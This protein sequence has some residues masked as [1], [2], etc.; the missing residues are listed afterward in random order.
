VIYNYIIS[1]FNSCCVRFSN[2]TER[3]N[4]EIGKELT[5]RVNKCFKFNSFT[6]WLR[7]LGSTFSTFTFAEIDTINYTATFYKIKILFMH[8]GEKK[9]KNWLPICP[10]R[11]R[12]QIQMY[13]CILNPITGSMVILFL[14][15][16]LN[17]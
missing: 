17:P 16:G 15:F 12:W 14:L 4:E 1:T 9:I 2:V 5:M 6:S 13:N 3:E 11:G 10:R 8:Y 7:Q